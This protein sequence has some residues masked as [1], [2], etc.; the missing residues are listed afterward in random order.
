MLS[1]A[2]V[3]S[4]LQRDLRG[5]WPWILGFLPG[6]GLLSPRMGFHPQRSTC[7]TSSQAAA[8]QDSSRSVNTNPTTASR[9]NRRQLGASRQSQ[10]HETRLQSAT[11]NENPPKRPLKTLTRAEIRGQERREDLLGAPDLPTSE[12]PYRQSGM[13]CLLIEI[14][15]GEPGDGI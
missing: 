5:N 13:D 11:A 1:S 6:R 2:E 14:S 10:T 12:A 8:F 3:T 9:A 15:R 4:C 7:S